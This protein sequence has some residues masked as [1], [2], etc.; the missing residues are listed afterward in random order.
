MGKA[1]TGTEHSASASRALEEPCLSLTKIHSYT[2]KGCSDLSPNV[3]FICLSKQMRSLLDMKAL[4]NMLISF[5]HQNHFL[6]QVPPRLLRSLPR[7]LELPLQSCP[8][9][10]TQPSNAWN[11]TTTTPIQEKCQKKIQRA[12]LDMNILLRGKQNCSVTESG[13]EVLGS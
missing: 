6:R 12:L 1:Q 7:A 5:I 10:H 4:I 11:G 2:K 13:Q 3:V 8:K 9:T